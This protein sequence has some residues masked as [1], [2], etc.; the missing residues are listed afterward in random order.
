MEEYIHLLEL[1]AV[2]NMLRAFWTHLQSHV[3]RHLCDNTVVVAA[4]WEG[5]SH[6]WLRYVLYS[7][8]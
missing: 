7:T 3:V 2:L 6:A 5:S 8:L 4:I 1:H